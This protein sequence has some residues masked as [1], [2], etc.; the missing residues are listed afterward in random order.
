MNDDQKKTA[1]CRIDPSFL[2]GNG[3]SQT[4][5]LAS[6]GPGIQFYN[7]VCCGDHLTAESILC[8][9]AGMNAQF[10]VK[11]NNSHDSIDCFDSFR[12]G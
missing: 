7:A 3:E 4:S 2:R 5:P 6:W 8:L 10:N 12:S 1:S 9:R 11:I